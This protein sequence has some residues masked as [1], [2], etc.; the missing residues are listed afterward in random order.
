[1]QKKTIILMVMVLVSLLLWMSDFGIQNSAFSFS[2]VARV[3]DKKWALDSITSQE[4]K[5]IQTILSQP[6]TYMGCGAQAYVFF[7]EDGHSVLKFLKK[8][9]FHVP[10]WMRLFPPLPYT[11]KKIMAKRNSCVKDFTSYQIAFNELREETGLILVHLDKTPLPFTATLIDANKKPH[12]VSLGEYAF[13]LQKKG[14]SVYSTLE[15]YVKEGNV[16]AAQA[17]L[18]S[19]VHLLKKRCKK[20]VADRDPNFSKNYAFLNTQAI[21]I[22]IGR[23]HHGAVRA[24]QIS[25]DFKAWLQNLSPELYSHFEEVYKGAFSK[26]LSSLESPS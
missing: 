15:R 6:F 23:L 25:S 18:T 4:E 8:K 7:S 24:P 9:R 17:S 2:Q 5:H 13:I 19:L 3:S 26:P 12:E 20:G 21:E 11:T 14:D 1:M 16:S 22:D 10:F